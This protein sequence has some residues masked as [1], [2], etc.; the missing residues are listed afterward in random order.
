VDSSENIFLSLFCLEMVIK[1]IAMGFF[2]HRES[3][4]RDS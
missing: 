2:V 4:L 1:I 3:Y